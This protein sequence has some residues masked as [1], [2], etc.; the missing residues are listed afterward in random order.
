MLLPSNLVANWIYC[1]QF[2]QAAGVI[3]GATLGSILKRDDAYIVFA[4]V[5][6]GITEPGRGKS[7]ITIWFIS[8]QKKDAGM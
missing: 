1:I 5:N 6:L 3:V 4:Y 8:R 2:C 7:K